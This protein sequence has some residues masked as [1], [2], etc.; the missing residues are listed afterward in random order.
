MCLDSLLSIYTERAA[1]VTVVWNEH[2]AVFFVVFH[3]SL[4]PYTK[5]IKLYHFEQLFAIK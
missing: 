4:S 2:S 3:S 1:I 5:I